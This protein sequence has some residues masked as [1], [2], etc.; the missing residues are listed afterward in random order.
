MSVRFSRRLTIVLFTTFYFIRS[1]PRFS[2]GIV[3]CVMESLNFHETFTVLAKTIRPH[4]TILN[5]IFIVF[6][7]EPSN[8]LSEEWSTILPTLNENRL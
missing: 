5:G 8:L 6:Y 2:Q 3:V 7:L 4:H 1:L